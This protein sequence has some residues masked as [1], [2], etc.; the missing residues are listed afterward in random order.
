MTFTPRAFSSTLF[1]EPRTTGRDTC[2]TCGV[3]GNSTGSPF[4]GLATV[5]AVRHPAAGGPALHTLQ[6]HRK[7]LLQC[8]S[9]GS[10]HC[11]LGLCV[12]RGCQVLLR[13][14]A[15]WD[16]KSRTQNSMHGLGHACTWPN[17]HDLLHVRC[18]ACNASTPHPAWHICSAH[19][20]LQQDSPYLAHGRLDF[21]PSF[22]TQCQAFS[23]LRLRPSNMG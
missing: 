16:T 7:R 3:I 20:C 22:L 2:T 9:F 17:L 13:P 4:N 23:R 6:R 21:V 5:P 14:A 10:R 18:I 19:I 1:T 11:A 12:Q 15:A 8:R